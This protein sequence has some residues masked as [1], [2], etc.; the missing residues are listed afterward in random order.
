VTEVPGPAED[1]VLAALCEVL[2][3]LADNERRTQQL[4]D[5]SH[6][7][8]AQRAEGRSWAEIVQSGDRPL[9][10][11]LLS[12]SLQSLTDA[13]ARF[14]RA[15]ARALYVDGVTM[16]RIAELFGVSRQRVSH[17][18][19]AEGE[20]AGSSSRRSDRARSRG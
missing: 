11:E 4:L 10:V 3:A 9:V 17:L 19:Q 20:A 5:K 16:E 7:L 13:G 6:I 1:E 12:D 14:R 18:L 15:Q 2:D 8:R